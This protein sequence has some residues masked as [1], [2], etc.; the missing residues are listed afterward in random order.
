MPPFFF[1][2]FIKLV[3]HSLVPVLCLNE[4]GTSQWPR[5]VPAFSIGHSPKIMSA[6]FKFFFQ[7]FP[8]YFYAHFF[9][10]G[11]VNLCSWTLWIGVFTI[12]TPLA[13]HP[14]NSLNGVFYHRYPFWHTICPHSFNTNF[15]GQICTESLR[16]LLFETALVIH[17]C[18]PFAWV[19]NLILYSICDGLSE[20][21]FSSTGSGL[22]NHSDKFR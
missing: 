20:L 21:V 10:N 1:L 15:Q 4:Q 16:E 9:L 12:G 14:P 19:S 5:P 6:Q 18:I 22:R 17:V 7:S 13:Y 3:R 8:I 11:N 2:L